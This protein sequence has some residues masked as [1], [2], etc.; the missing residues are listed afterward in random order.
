[1]LDVAAT[2]LWQEI[3]AANSYRDDFT[4]K[5]LELIRR[6]A[7]QEHDKS[8]EACSDV[9]NHSFEF[10][11]LILP[12]IIMDNPRVRLRPMLPP[13]APEPLR[14]FMEALSRRLQWQ[15]NEWSRA[16]HLGEILQEHA[17]DW[18]FG[19][20]VGAI[21]SAPSPDTDPSDPNTQFPQ[22]LLRVSPQG[23][24]FDPRASSFRTARFSYRRFVID[25]ESLKARARADDSW[26]KDA[27]ESLHTEE[28]PADDWS[29]AEGS[30]LTIG[31]RTEGPAR[32][33][34]IY[35]QVWVKEHEL[36][37]ARELGGRARGFNGTIFTI[38]EHG[39]GVE[40]REPRPFFGPAA[41]P[42]RMAGCYMV[43]GR[44]YPLS[45]LVATARQQ[46]EL[47]LV[48]DANSQGVKDYKQIG[49]I[50]SDHAKVG[51]VI[52]DG[53]HMNL[54]SVEDLAS[55]IVQNHELG[56]LTPQML[57]MEA[58]MRDRLNRNSGID[59]ARR[60]QPRG[61]SATEADITD[62]AGS[63]RLR[64]MQQ[65]F[66]RFVREVFEGVI[67]YMAAG[68]LK[69]PLPDDS[70]LIEIEPMSMSRPSELVMQ[71]RLSIEINAA[72]QI[73]QG[74]V[75]MPWVDWGMFA[76]RIGDALDNPD[77]ARMFSPEIAMALMAARQSDAE[78][79]VGGAST[80]G[81]QGPAP[82]PRLTGGAKGRA[83]GRNGISN[84]PSGYTTG[85]RMGA[86]V[87]R[88]GSM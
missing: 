24:G 37:T 16:V 6:Y 30:L 42:Y 36:E 72:M 67:W 51:E 35:W 82:A 27:I 25:H 3:E 5:P 85:A 13:D 52:V 49:L 59:D 33:P 32:D 48:A 63:V 7:G 57:Q 88:N 80:D 69:Q 50:D 65:R 55:A 62:R 64:Q 45:P 4:K 31:K 78:Q 12:Q 66:A 14:K 86:R 40:I 10:V 56:G 34:V 28:V 29:M 18:S 77:F 53:E 83:S 21:A 20:C 74:M 2:N 61:V 58:L 26:I 44:P 76:Q 38:A 71:Q 79:G 73:G 39:G 41:G 84:A 11:S 70:L 46:E 60:G 19:W 75:T 43:P 15:A 23:F 68:I 87:R 9:E 1:M 54:Y 8:E 81:V 47:N 17:Y 22:R